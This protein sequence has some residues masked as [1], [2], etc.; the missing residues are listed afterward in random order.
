LAGEPAGG[1][2]SPEGISENGDASHYGKE[3]NMRGNAYK[4]LCKVK[5]PS[6]REYFY[7]Y[8]KFSHFSVS[9]FQ[10]VKPVK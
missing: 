8:L 5:V 7:F 9:P 1:L 3:S 4:R 6:L 10:I 2:Q